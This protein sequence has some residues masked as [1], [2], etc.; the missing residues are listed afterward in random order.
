VMASP[1]FGARFHVTMPKR[2]FNSTASHF[3]PGVV[4]RAGNHPQVVG[5]RILRIFLEL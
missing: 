4:R 1:H 2:P 5:T 3:I